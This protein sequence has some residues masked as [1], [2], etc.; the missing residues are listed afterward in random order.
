MNSPLQ[1]LN[2]SLISEDDW[3]KYFFATKTTKSIYK[4]LKT[5][6][7]FY[8]RILFTQLDTMPAY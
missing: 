5:A 1:F 2:L 7:W 8:C 4:I 3:L 6:L